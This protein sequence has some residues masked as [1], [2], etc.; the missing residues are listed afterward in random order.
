MKD[1]RDKRDVKKKGRGRAGVGSGEVAT[2]L[3]ICLTLLQS[4]RR[5]CLKF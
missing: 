1:K 2:I 4:R 3:D 5:R